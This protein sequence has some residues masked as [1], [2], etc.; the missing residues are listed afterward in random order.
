MNCSTHADELLGSCGRVVQLML[1]SL[2]I[3]AYEFIRL[4][5]SVDKDF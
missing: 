4:Y 2:P 1:M 5:V 3:H